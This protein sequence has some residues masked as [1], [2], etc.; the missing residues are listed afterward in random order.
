MRRTLLA[1]SLFCSAAA[2]AQ[3]VA[4]F[5]ALPLTGTDSFYVNYTSP[6]QDVGFDNGLAHFPCV[7]DTSGGF[8]F[9]S[10][11]FVYSRKTDS[12]TGGF[13][14][15]YTAKA[16]K[17]VDGSTKYAVAFGVTNKV[18]LKNA[19]VGQHV[20]GVYLTNNSYAYNT[21]RDGDNF[22]RKFGDTT[23]TGSGLPQGTVPDFFK[24]VIRGYRSG[25]LTTDSV[26]FFLADYRAPGTANDYIIRD[27]RWVPL[28]SL[29]K[30][31]SLQFVLS[32]SD[33]GQF[34]MNTPAYFCIDNFTTNEDNISVP[35]SPAL[36]AA[37]VYPNPAVGQLFVELKDKGAQ[38]I[39]IMDL[40]GRTVLSRRVAQAT[41]VLDI[42]ALQPG[43]YMLQIDGTGR[44]A[45]SRF[46]KK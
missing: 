5:E 38:Q 31:D 20:S 8:D 22:S 4:D 41:E 1:L 19:A 28:G 16:G 44:S 9:L 14:N 18:I 12:A 13:T 37:K 6:G 27:W 33:N 25:A 7:F 43:I 34:G 42:S 45:T 3:T 10:Y 35:Q 26:E 17:G 29:G 40:S 36:A 46:V 21:I 23:G 11:G 30:I 15:Q 24:I 39:R 2:T 32:S